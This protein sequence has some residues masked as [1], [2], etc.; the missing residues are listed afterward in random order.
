MFVGFVVSI[1]RENMVIFEKQNIFCSFASLFFTPYN[2][3]SK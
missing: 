3:G 2:G 1:M